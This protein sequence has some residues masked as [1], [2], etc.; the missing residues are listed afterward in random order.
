MDGGRGLTGADELVR[1][2]L[3][4]RGHFLHTAA[5]VFLLAPL[6]KADGVGLVL[7]DRVGAGRVLDITLESRTVV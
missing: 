2:V 7:L 6:A 4:V 5:A 3:Y 1:I